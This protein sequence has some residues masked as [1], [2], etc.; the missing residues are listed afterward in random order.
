M[1]RLATYLALHGAIVLTISLVAGLLLHKAIRLGQ[2]VAAW[3]LAHAGVSSRGVMLMAIAAITSWVALP[4]RPLSAFVWLIL[5]FVWT[6][7]AAMVIAAA[8]RERGVTWGGSAVNRVVF[9]L[10]V[11]SAVTVFPAALLLIAG[12]VIGLQAS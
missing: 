11:T 6:S 7:T 8:T 1:E 10:Y 3:H 12:L 2:P 9:A 4:P 5:T